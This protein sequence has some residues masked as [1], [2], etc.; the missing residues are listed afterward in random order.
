[1][2]AGAA[3]FS[4]ERLLNQESAVGISV[5]ASYDDDFWWRGG[6]LPYY[7]WYYFNKQASGL[8]MEA[9]GGV[10][11][12][13]QQ[14]YD[15]YFEV[16]SV[17]THFGAGLGFALGYKFLSQRGWV[18]E[19]YGGVGRNFVEDINTSRAYPRFGVNIGRRFGN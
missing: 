12:E 8:F 4:Y 15:G 10:F 5:L 9:N 14:I 7:R 11:W 13:N 16:A 17:E 1:V 19:C 6:V 2:I 3:E 18:G